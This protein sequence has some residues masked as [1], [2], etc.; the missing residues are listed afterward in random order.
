MKHTAYKASG[1]DI[2]AADRLISK[3]KGPISSTKNKAVLDNMS[4]FGCF[5]ELNAIK[6]Y[7]NPVLVSSNDGVG[8]KLKIAIDIGKHDT[9]GLDCVAMC[10]NDIVVQG[11]EPLFFLDYFASGRL[12]VDI[13]ETVISGVAVGCKEAGCALI[14][15]ET[16]EMPGLYADGDYDLAG[17]TVGGIEKDRII[18]GGKVVAGDVVLGIASGGLHSNGFSLVRRI[19][20]SN[21][22]FS[23]LKET[24]FS[25]GE[26]L[27][28]YLLKP[29]RIY[30][31]SVLE[32]LEDLSNQNVYENMHG[33]A[34]ITGGGIGGNLNRIIPD[35]LYAEIDAE[36]WTMH[37]VFSWLARHGKLT[38]G[39]ILTTFNCG[40]GLI[41]V[42]DGAIAD[43]VQ[44]ALEKK[45][46]TV[47]NIGHVREGK[48]AENGLNEKVKILNI[49]T[50]NIT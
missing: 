37:P 48:P 19:V 40:L 12:D 44:K 49:N 20:E 25:E 14:G 9:V 39:D 5:F 42:C 31:R 11:A 2:K 38:A 21:S 47:F 17:F 29:T 7:Q 6:K 23:Y 27:G 46:E 45:G 24:D 41:A 22:Q 10:V 36:K 33:M 34:H 4:G 13:A 30:V 3:I 50:L 1:V 35:G 32:M 18:D 15:G 43:Q 28:A 16:A 26:T 8:T